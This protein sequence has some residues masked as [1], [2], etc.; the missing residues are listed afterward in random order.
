M[1]K[2]EPFKECALPFSQPTT[3]GECMICLALFDTAQ[4]HMQ[5]LPMILCR[6]CTI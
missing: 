5:C 1:N 6:F 4:K 3:Q 2:T